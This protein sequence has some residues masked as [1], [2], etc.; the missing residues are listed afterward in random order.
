MH[1]QQINI[2]D[3]TLREAGYLNNWEFNQE[4]CKKYI[5]DLNKSKVE[6]IEVG[7]LKDGNFSQNQTLFNQIE[8]INNIISNDST[9]KICAMIMVDEFD[10]NKIVPKTSEI[11]LD[12]IRLSFKKHQINQAYEYLNK[13]KECGYELFINP[14]YVDSY[15]DLELIELFE[16]LSEFMPNY[17]SIVDTNGFLKEKDILRIYYLIKNHFD[18]NVGICLHLHNNLHMAF[19]NAVQLIK[20]NN[21]RNLIIDS[22]ILG[23]GRNDGNIPT[24]Q[25]MYYLSEY[26]YKNYNLNPIIELSR[27]NNLMSTEF[28]TKNKVLKPKF[29]NLISKS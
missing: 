19:Y 11:K 13:I 6:Y 28:F 3:C 14:T 2:L 5:Q 9:S 24:E 1:K 16:K 15:C 4:F 10:I 12:C 8:D 18:K 22:T 7:F 21:D 20:E 26:Y 27:H 29:Q 25:I 17:I 23:I